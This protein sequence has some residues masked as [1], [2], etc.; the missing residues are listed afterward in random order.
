MQNNQPYNL[1]FDFCKVNLNDTAL[2]Y[3][4]AEQSS[5]NNRIT[6]THNVLSLLLEGH[7]EAHTG[8]HTFSIENNKFFL[9]QSGNSLMTEK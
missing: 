1:P 8:G 3:Y 2:Y 5:T 4:T 7:K 6:F 9:L